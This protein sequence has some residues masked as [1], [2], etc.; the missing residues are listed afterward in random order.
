MDI[1]AVLKSLPHRFPFL[2]V[3]RVLAVEANKYIHALK[4]VTINEPF[5]PGHFPNHPV[6][7]GVLIIEALAQAAAILSFETLGT[8]PDADSVYYLCGVDNTRFKKP[9]MA[10]DQ[11]ILEVDLIR[12]SRGIWKYNARA[13][14]DGQV[15]TECDLLCAVRPS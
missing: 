5:F 15:V 10:G 6:M 14:V 11:L 4:N 2:L 1:H 3:D 13:K 12:H 8:T 9:V 7:P